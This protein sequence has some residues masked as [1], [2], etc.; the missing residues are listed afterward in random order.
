MKAFKNFIAVLLVFSFNLYSNKISDAIDAGI[1]WLKV[2]QNSD[3]S[4]GGDTTVSTYVST[5]TV[6]EALGVLNP[7]D[8]LYIKGIT[9]LDSLEVKNSGHLSQKIKALAPSDVNITSLQDTLLSYYSPPIGG[10][11]FDKEKRDVLSTAFALISL[12]ESNY[13][14]N[15]N[16]GWSIGYLMDEQDTAGFWRYNDE[17]ISNIYLT[18]LTLISLERFHGIYDLSTQIKNG[19]SWLLSQQNTNGSFGKDTT[20]IYESALSLMALQGGYGLEGIGYR[21]GI[22]YRVIWYSA[23]NKTK[24]FLLSLQD[25]D[26]SWNNNAYET[27]LI[28]LVSKIGKLPLTGRKHLLDLANSFGRVVI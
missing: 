28:I 18:A 11:T 20:S 21:E 17:N 8:S 14:V 15:E 27:A 2:S 12:H 19:I 16:I 3:G 6:C 7:S 23:I 13:S 24:N 9:Y 1:R 10:F 4:W 22:D 26:G 25:S 5:A